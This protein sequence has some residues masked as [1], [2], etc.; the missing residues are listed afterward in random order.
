MALSIPN[1]LHEAAHNPSKHIA[2]AY[3]VFSGKLITMK[4]GYDHTD[5]G[6]SQ[7]AA[8]GYW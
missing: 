5:A 4:R 8:V 7:D 3:V 6:G 1:N 2:W